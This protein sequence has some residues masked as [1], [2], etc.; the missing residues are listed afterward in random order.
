M[1]NFGGEFQNALRVPAAVTRLTVYR[2]QQVQFAP[3]LIRILNRGAS[4]LKNIDLSETSRL[5]RDYLHQ[6]LLG[7]FALYPKVMK[8]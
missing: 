6:K 1:S 8:R 4:R 5:V 3:I 2:R 7:G